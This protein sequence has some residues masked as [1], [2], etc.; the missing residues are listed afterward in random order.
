MLERLGRSRTVAACMAD[1]FDGEYEAADFQPLIDG[2]G[3]YTDVDLV[4]LEQMVS[5]E[6]KCTDDD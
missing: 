4:L 3:D 1:E 6:R 5:A 2:R